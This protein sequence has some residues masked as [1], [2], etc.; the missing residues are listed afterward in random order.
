[1]TVKAANEALLYLKAKRLIEI[2]NGGID[3]IYMVTALGVKEVEK[4]ITHQSNIL[5]QQNQKD[6]LERENLALQNEALKYQLRIRDQDAEI[7]RLTVENLQLQNRNQKRT[8]LYM[9]LSA[10]LGA[11][12]GALVSSLSQLGSILKVY[13]Q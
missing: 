1:M 4:I 7:K 11:A 13:L 3:D 10:V 8:I 5:K 12:A 2:S 9:I 6:Q